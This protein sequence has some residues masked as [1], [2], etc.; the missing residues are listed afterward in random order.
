MKKQF[1]V[2]VVQSNLV[3]EDVAANIDHFDKLLS[4]ENLRSISTDLILLPEMFTT[5]FS[6]RSQALAESMH[7][8]TATWLKEKSVALN[9]AIA[10]S[11]I[12]ADEEKYFNRFLLAQPNQELVWYDKRHLFR[13]SSENDHYS[14]G[15]SHQCLEIQ[16]LMLSPQI[17][18]D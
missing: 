3:W 17:C 5:G 11:A 8:R 1:T 16:G 7:D 2:T 14:A 15:Q 6:M 4:V 13:M 12:I 9:C 10:G 18:Y